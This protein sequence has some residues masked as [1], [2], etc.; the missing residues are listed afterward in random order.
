M[1]NDKQ[2]KLK[3][4]FIY[5]ALTLFAAAALSILFFFIINDSKNV[6]ISPG[7]LISA[8]RPFIYGAIIAYILVPMCNFYERHI[9]NLFS[10]KFGWNKE[11]SEKAASIIA[12]ALSLGTA[13]LI[14]YLLLSMII[15]QLIVS[16][17]L[18]VSNFDTYYENIT[19]WVSNLFKN[20]DVLRGYFETIS[21]TITETAS[22][23]LKNELLPNTKTFIS[24]FSSGVLSA[25]S[26]LKNIFIGI[27][28]A[29]YLLSSR[30]AFAAQGRIFIHCI[31]KE[32][33]ADR[34]L[35]EVRFANKMF[36][37]FISGRLVDSAIIGILCF[38]GLSIM[39]MPYSLLISVLV[40]VTNVIPFFGPFI[41]G[42]P[43]GFLILMVSPVKCVWFIIFI[44]ILQQFD[45]N[46]LGPKI[47]GE[48]TNLNSFWVL[49][50]IMLFSGL[51]GF[52]GMIIGVPVFAVI[53]HIAQELIMK[54]MKKHGYVPTPEDAEISL[55][56][57]YLKEQEPSDENTDKKSTKKVSLFKKI[58][59]KKKEG[60][61]PS[62]K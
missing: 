9:N 28:V 13:I 26:I 62:K 34:F 11:K 19:T 10:V 36:M 29:I 20:N 60:K 12:I 30:E 53:Y 54:G 44:I 27:I 52:I 46:I 15:P 31:M 32:K 4:K 42:I 5:I 21:D 55:L 45:G 35:E 38:I 25:V 37:G 58:L 7:K 6:N 16:L 8:V 61:K 50:A 51:F 47:L 43:A 22:G 59:L 2:K 33:H 24:S 14:I 3:K 48:M 41:G 40:G 18:I 39:K 56:N 23:F 1:E 49:F 17:T 57:A